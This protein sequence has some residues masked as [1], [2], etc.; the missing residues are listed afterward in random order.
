MTLR[1]KRT[2]L[3]EDAVGSRASVASAAS[4]T[5]A[6]TTMTS[7]AIL[8]VL[9]GTA[10]AA[11][12]AAHRAQV[13]VTPAPDA[14]HETAPPQMIERAPA[15]NATLPAM[16]PADAPSPVQTGPTSVEHGEL[17]PLNGTAMAAQTAETASHH[18]AGLAAPANHSVA[19]SAAAAGMATTTSSDPLAIDTDQALGGALAI[20]DGFGQQLT[21]TLGALTA[22]ITALTTTIQSSL[23]NLTSLVD[24]TAATRTITTSIDQLAQTLTSTT[25]NLTAI[26]EA[27]TDSLADL[28]SIVTDQASGTATAL[29][30][31]LPAALLGGPDAPQ[32]DTVFETA[33]AQEN[34]SRLETPTIDPHKSAASG[35]FL[36]TGDDLLPFAVELPLLQL[37][38]MG[39]SYAEVVDLHDSTFST[40]GH[41][42]HG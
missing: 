36:H 32:I 2:R 35:S 30:D 42:L 3:P 39:Q 1:A 8:G 31:T 13:Q 33:F 29:L 5:V 23:D 15:H 16:E 11:R 10:E 27:T 21:Q 26:A 20:V 25:S 28:T 40:W 34:A 24:L 22:D 17:A 4:E 7:A 6:L 38:F 9:A 18:D 12:E 19:G 14:S 37:G 41:G